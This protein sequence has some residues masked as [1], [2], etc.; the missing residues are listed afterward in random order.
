MLTSGFAS[1]CTIHTSCA[2]WPSP[3]C[4]HPFSTVISGGAADEK[5]SWNLISRCSLCKETE[6]GFHLSAKSL[7]FTMRKLVNYFVL[8]TENTERGRLNPGS[9]VFSSL[10]LCVSVIYNLQ[11]YELSPVCSS[12]SCAKW[13]C[14]CCCVFQYHVDPLRRSAIKLIRPKGNQSDASR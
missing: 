6:K 12:G 9:A 4:T 1:P 7:K 3:A 5:K 13:R 2:S 14:Y 10:V 8:C 11:L